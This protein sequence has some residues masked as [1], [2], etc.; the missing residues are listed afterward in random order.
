MAKA[1]SRTSCSLMIALHESLEIP[2]SFAAVVGEIENEYAI[3]ALRALEDLRM[4]QRADRVMIPGAPMVLHARARELII[5]RFTFVSLR[6]VNQLDE[7]VDLLSCGRLQD[8]ALWAV[9]EIL[10]HLFQKRR[11]GTT[12]LL[13]IFEAVGIRT[14]AARVLDLFLTRRDLGHGVREIAGRAPEIDLK[15]ERVLARLAFEDPVQGRVR[16]ESAIPV[17]LPVNL[18]RRK[19][20]RER[21]AGHHMLGTDLV[22]RIVEIDEITRLDIN[23]PQAQTHLAGIDPVEVD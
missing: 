14:G 6:A 5:L 8:L 10:R 16:D 22:G 4:A 23:R 2:R 19:A 3:D 1:R 13:Q 9:L 15:S 11:Q 21:T 20:G 18:D 12:Q 7:V 17:M